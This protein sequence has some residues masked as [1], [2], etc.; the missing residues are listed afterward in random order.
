MLSFYSFHF[1]FS[2][3]IHPSS[4]LPPLH[5]PPPPPLVPQ[6][7]CFFIPLQKS[8]GFPVK[9]TEHGI[10]RHNTM[11]HIFLYQG[12]DEASGRNKGSQEWAKE[13]EKTPLPLLGVSQT[14][15]VKQPQY[16]SRGSSSD[17]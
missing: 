8:E 2:H 3:I 6:T 16:V 7:H 12:L 4:S 17:A 15:Q 5:S 1:F 11:R 10:T 9:S 13:S 14:S